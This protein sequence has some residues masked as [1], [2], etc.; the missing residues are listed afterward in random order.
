MWR[1]YNLLPESLREATCPGLCG[2]YI[3]EAL[4][5]RNRVSPSDRGPRGLVQYSTL[6]ERI[7][8]TDEAFEELYPGIPRQVYGPLTE[9][10]QRA[11]ERAQ[12]STDARRHALCYG[13]L[14]QEPLRPAAEFMRAYLRRCGPKLLTALQSYTA[15]HFRFTNGKS[16]G[17]VAKP[18]FPAPSAR[19]GRGNVGGG[20]ALFRE[21]LKCFADHFALDQTP[22]GDE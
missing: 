2:M 20:L 7:R 12:D 4:T 17:A 8:V 9:G 1:R 11:L 19:A 18:F 14:V 16:I 22:D 5:C 13:R 15:K 3:F 10:A 6:E 21:V